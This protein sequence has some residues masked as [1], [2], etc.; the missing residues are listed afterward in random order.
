MGMSPEMGANLIPDSGGSRP[1]GK[2]SQAL[3]EESVRKGHPPESGSSSQGRIEETEIG[4]T[5]VSRA[6]SSVLPSGLVLM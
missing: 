5:A 1:L 2:R 3:P 4:S 6:H